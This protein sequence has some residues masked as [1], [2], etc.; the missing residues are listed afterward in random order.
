M[1]RALCAMGVATFLTACGGGGGTNNQTAQQGTSID[2]YPSLGKFESGTVNL[3]SI[4][5][6]VLSTGSLQNGTAKLSANIGC[7]PAIIEIS[8]GRYYDEGL[9]KFIDMGNDLKLRAATPCYSENSEIGVTGFTEIA[10]QKASATLSAASITDANTYVKDKYANEL[11]SILI[12]PDLIGSTQDAKNLKD[13]PNGKYALKLAAF[14]VVAAKYSQ[15]TIRM[16]H[17]AATNVKSTGYIDGGI[18]GGYSASSFKADFNTAIDNYS[19]SYAQAL[20]S[21]KEQAKINSNSTAIPEIVRTEEFAALMNLLSIPPKSPGFTGISNATDIQNSNNYLPNT[22]V[23]NCYGETDSNTSVFSSTSKCS[24][25]YLTFLPYG[26]LPSTTQLFKIGRPENSRLT[27]SGSLVGPLTTFE[28][29]PIARNTSLNVTYTDEVKGKSITITGTAIDMK[30]VSGGDAYTRPSSW[31]SG[32][33]QCRTIEYRN[34]SINIT[35]QYGTRS[36][37]N[38]NVCADDSFEA[39]MEDLSGR[40]RIFKYFAKGENQQSV[41]F[42]NTTTPLIFEQA[43][44]L[45]AN[46]GTTLSSLALNFKSGKIT[47]PTNLNDSITLESDGNGAAKITLKKS[48]IISTS[49]IPTHIL[50]DRPIP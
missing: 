5:G 25:P 11:A 21:S 47:Y 22:T 18:T 2:V 31:V 37:R 30:F 28:G 23:I 35:N 14:S 27:I 20:Q 12:K 13:S 10:Y 33:Q 48:G 46:T 34:A 9:D 49:I 24:S 41:I 40:P 6:K 39:P 4:D 8:K 3:L 1:K 43:N 29:Y 15:D 50:L 45:G 32:G 17:D 38:F 7:Q 42:D 44:N 19:S 36:L 16:I 26:F